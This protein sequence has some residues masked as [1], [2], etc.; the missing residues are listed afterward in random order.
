M[1]RALAIAVQGWGQVAPN[2]LV[3]A[4]LLRDGE[5][6]GEGYHAVFGG[7]HAEVAALESCDD[8]RGA[9]CV[10]T[11]E[12]CAHEGKTA[13]CV[14]ALIRAGVARVVVAIPD[15]NPAAGGGIDRLLQAGI[16]V[17][18]GLCEA[19]A[20]ALNAP[21]LFCASRADRPFVALKLAT[22]L[23]GQL[24][25]ASGKSQWLSGSEA[26]AFVQWL[27]A[28]FGAIGVGRGTAV[29]DDPLLTVRGPLEPRSPP[30]RVVFARD[31][32][33]PPS[34]RMFDTD[35]ATAVVV[36]LHSRVADVSEVVVNKEVMVIGADSLTA[37]M[38]SLRRRGIQSILIEG[39]GRL[40]T[41][42]L[43][44][45]LVDRLYWIQ[46]PRWL[47]S[48]TPAFTRTPISLDLA[49]SWRVTDRRAL[50]PD[51]LLVVDRRLCLQA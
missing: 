10:V 47:G 22:S 17:S 13:P 7:P 49:E 14:D 20:A 43:D 39:G 46:A 24:A 6:V 12:P 34:L 9:T 1:E 4:V 38:E 19:H 16:D 35:P 28:G 40:A 29:A 36:V 32:E 33:I 30:T 2:P 18:V 26:R 15:P 45:G 51:T 8:P 27:R 37:A 21:F 31:G 50:G 41:S 3:G 5:I 25:D 48:G 44:D 11:L 42:L 23:D